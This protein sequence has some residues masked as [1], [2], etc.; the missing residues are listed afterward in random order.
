ML[1]ALARPSMKADVTWS[2][3][4][5]RWYQNI[6]GSQA[7]AGMVVVPESALQIAAVYRAVNVLAHAVAGIPLVVYR[8]LED[9]G[10]ERAREHSAFGLLHDR[11]NQWQTSFR[12]RHLLTTQAILWG[13][14]FSEIRP[15][16]GGIGG[17]V[18]LNPDTTRVVD[19]LRDGRLL[20]VTRDV[21]LGRSGVERTLVQ[22]EVLHVRGFSIDGISGIPLTKL[23]RNAMGLALSSEKHGSMF[24][25]NGARLNGILTTPAA[26][27]PEVRKE[28][29]RAWKRQYGG[30]GSS[31]ATPLLTGGMDYKP[32]SANNR[33]SQWLEARNF[34]VEELLRFVGVPGVL[35]GYP[36]KTATY[37]SA[38][39]FFLSFVTHSVRPWTEN[40]SAEISSSVVTGSPEFYA[41]FILEGLLRGDI[42][43][44]YDAHRLAIASGWKSRN[45]V[46][47]AEDMNRGPEDL[48][49]FLEPLNM[50]EAGSDRDEGGGSSAGTP[51]SRS[52]DGNGSA[53]SDRN[54]LEAIVRKSVERLVRKEVAALAGTGTRRG[55]AFRFANDRK[56]WTDWLES[57]YGEHELALAEE[58]GIS[59]TSARWY[60]NA[61]RARLRTLDPTAI[62][63]LEVESASALL[64]LTLNTNGGPT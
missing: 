62:E 22:D 33:D 45:E 64:R 38:E 4:D 2:P 48:D 17:L 59:S 23:A 44:R 57:F 49:T 41:A 54:Q 5:T 25:R 58:L 10:K 52:N 8:R 31:G 7:D 16:P 53:S 43:T 63:T 37:A 32:I 39:Q 30:S 9:D 6:G 29:E 46:R 35:V 36:D 42:K 51:G 11:P 13:Q 34:Q 50:V 14:H 12:W 61:Q 28:N 19:Q 24:L 60:C 55:A 26:M 3:L 20:Y 56:G 15:G 47:V 27:L 21:V 18:P 1:S 40:I